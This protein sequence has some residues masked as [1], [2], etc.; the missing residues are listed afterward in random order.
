MSLWTRKEREHDEFLFNPLSSPEHAVRARRP[1]FDAVTMALHWA[2]V[3]LVLSL[4]TT[5]WLHGQA[6]VRQ[7]DYTPMLLWLH[8]SLGATVWAVTA[9]RLVWRL[10]G[11]KLPPFPETMSSRHRTIVKASEYALYALLL[12]QPVTGLLTSLFNG[13]P[14]P[15]LLWDVSPLTRDVPLRDAL[16]TVHVFGARALGI[17]ALGHAAAALFHHFVLRDDVL[18]CMAPVV[19]E[20]PPARVTQEVS[21]P[22]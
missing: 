2:T 13:H 7:S 10:T 18:V 12:T 6:E 1:P 19:A 17:L 3:L 14:F 22:P 11:A 20:T 16:H 5:A 8:R 15:L 4:F 21:A 9:L